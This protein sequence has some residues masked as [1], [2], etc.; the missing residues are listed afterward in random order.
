M[1]D[2]KSTCVV[3]QTRKQIRMF[4][5]IRLIIVIIH[6]RLRFQAS[7]SEVFPNKNSSKMTF[8]TLTTSFA[9]QKPFETA[10]SKSLQH[11][12]G[13]L[14]YLWTLSG[15]TQLTGLRKVP[16]RM[17]Q[18]QISILLL[19]WNTVGTWSW[20]FQIDMTWRISL[21]C[22]NIFSLLNSIILKLSENGDINFKYFLETPT[23]LGINYL[24]LI[25]WLTI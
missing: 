3:P 5:I 23:F 4:Y 13:K 9:W 20:Q 17:C 19:I 8:Q 12:P 18:F 21:W 25:L 11:C 7:S 10:N 2:K 1:V 24:K 22:L 14:V 16:K 6:T 15:S